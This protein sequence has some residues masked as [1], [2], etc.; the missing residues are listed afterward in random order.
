MLTLGALQFHSNTIPGMLHQR[1]LDFPDTPCYLFPEK[2]QTCTWRFV[3]KEVQAVAASLRRLGVRRQD[4]IAILMEGCPEQIICI[5]AAIAAGG[6]AVPLSTYLTKE[7]LKDC[8]LEARPAVFIM[9]SAEHHLAYSQL[10]DVVADQTGG[11][12]LSE[13]RWIPQQ[14]FVQGSPV[15]PASGFQPYE[16]LKAPLEPE[17]PAMDVAALTAYEPAFLLFSS[18]T[19]GRPKAILRSAAAFTSRKPV[20]KSQKPNAFQ[21]FLSRKGNAYVNRFVA[22]NL[23]PLYHLAGIGMMLTPLQ[24]CNARLAMLA[25]FNPVRGLDAIAQTK[26]RFLVGT[27]HMVQAILALEHASPTRLESVLGVLFASAALQPHVLEQAIQGFKNLYFFFVSY[28]S[29]ETGVVANGICFIPNRRHT[30]V[31]LLLRI[32]RSMNY[33]DGEIPLESFT[34]TPASIGGRIAHQV[35]VGIRDIHTDEWLPAGQEGEILVRSYRLVPGSTH[36]PIEAEG[37]F[38]TGDLGYVDSHN[39][40]MITDRLKR[41]ISR[42]GEKIAPAEIERVIKRQPGIEE[43]LVLGLPD[44]LYGE[45][46]AAAFTEK[47]GASVSVA[48][49]REALHTSLSTFK[50][51]QHFL[52]LPVLP[53]NATGKI[54]VAKVRNELLQMIDREYV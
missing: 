12:A 19:T 27:P 34:S 48:A 35:E 7:E 13:A 47:I 43:V 28:G 15:Q 26:A 44:A 18:G 8:L 39:C 38:R 17:K 6:V 42:G 21:S 51:P 16:A 41:I 46:V 1:A 9:G 5:Y 2:D 36:A 31:S 10:T 4:R 20:D 22:L 30:A 54:D 37:W 45:V 23:L 11:Q 49:L 32:L 25:R 50:V 14:A 40:I 3:W 29:T 33:L 53:L 24:V 52:R